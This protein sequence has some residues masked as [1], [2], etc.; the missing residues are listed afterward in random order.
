MKNSA[1]GWEAQTM[2]IVD[3]AIQP[4]LFLKSDFHRNGQQKNQA[5]IC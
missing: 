1:G 5:K 4:V 3:M 2:D